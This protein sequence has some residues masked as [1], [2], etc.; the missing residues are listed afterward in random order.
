M[1][2]YVVNFT[3]VST[4]PISVEEQSVDKTS[5]DVSLFGYIRLRFG[6]E[7]Q[8]NLLHLL[9]NYACVE[10]PLNPGNP[11]TSRAINNLL[12]APVRGQ[13]WY[14][15]TA[16]LLNSW[17]GD[18]WLPLQTID[19]VAANWGSIGDGQQLPRPVSQ[20]TGYVFEYDECIWSV[21]PSV[22]ESYFTS[23]DC[24]ADQVDSTV[25]MEYD[26]LGSGTHP[27]TVNYLIIGIRGNKNLG[28]SPVIPPDV[29]PTVTPTINITPT[30]TPT[31]T[32]V[33]TPTPTTTPAPSADILGL[34][35]RLYTSPSP[36]D[37]GG[38]GPGGVDTRLYST[39]ERRIVSYLFSPVGYVDRG[40]TY[41]EVQQPYYVSLQNLSGG[42]P[43]Y[44][45]NF[46]WVTLSAMG[47]WWNDSGNPYA[48]YNLA[49]YMTLVPKY[50]GGAGADTNYLR[51]G[52][53]ASMLCRMSITPTFNNS[54]WFDRY[55]S[56]RMEYSISG[57]VILTDSAGNSQDWWIPQTPTEVGGAN[58]HDPV[59]WVHP[60]SY[61]HYRH[62][63]ECLGCH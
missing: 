18:R 23:M 22:Y 31:G 1:N 36:G 32:P 44:T 8:E 10:D 51:T 57:R 61:G 27:G 29:T 21:A 49:S 19:D 60:V 28:S 62:C 34:D 13:F 25:T 38:P 45:V 63:E 2:T 20:T 48:K 33:S 55:T 14:N 24:R 40:T 50:Y 35:T 5:T 30:V 11:D 4:S 54:S 26:T 9:E 56:Y 7:L 37:P 58:G 12:E 3:D 46:R 42:V 52:V 15:T 16:E 43:P 17:V 59:T 39:C 6:D 47:G 41:D 53:D